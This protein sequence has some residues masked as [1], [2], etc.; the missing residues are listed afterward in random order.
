MRAERNA[1]FFDFTYFCQRIHLIAAAIGQYRPRPTI[2]PMNATRA[3]QYIQPGTQ[4]EVVSVA[5]DDLGF[6]GIDQ[7]MLVHGFYCARGPNRHKY[8]GFDGSMCGFHETGTRLGLAICRLKGEFHFR[9]KIAK[10]TRSEEHTS[11]L[12]SRE[13]LVCR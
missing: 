9:T 2:E 1:F 4:V 7:L 12:Q 10:T 13:N 5:Q 8:R 11:E 6:Y 3:V